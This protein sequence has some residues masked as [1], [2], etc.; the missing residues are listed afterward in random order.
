MSGV[1]LLKP[2]VEVPG[3]PDI[4]SSRARDAPKEVNAF[5]GESPPQLR[6]SVR[7]RKS[8]GGQPSPSCSLSLRM[9]ES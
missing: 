6:Y 8:Y 9:T 4:P 2:L 3:N 5:H 7:L 1:V